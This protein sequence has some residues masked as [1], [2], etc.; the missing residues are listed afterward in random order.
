MTEPEETADWTSRRYYRRAVEAALWGMPMVS[1]QAMLAAFR[2]VDG[3]F[4]DIVYFS[5]LPDWRWQITTPNATT[6]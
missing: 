5:R 2:G 4:G 1:T 6:I 3:Q